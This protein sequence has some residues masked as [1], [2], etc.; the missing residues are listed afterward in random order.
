MTMDEKNHKMKTQNTV[1]DISTTKR[2]PRDIQQSNDN[3]NGIPP[4]APMKKKIKINLTNNNKSS[5]IQENHHDKEVDDI[6]SKQWLFTLNTSTEQEIHHVRWMMAT[7]ESY[8]TFTHVVGTRK[9]NILRGYFETNIPYTKEEIFTLL[10]KDY[11]NKQE[12]VVNFQKLN[13]QHVQADIPY[14]GI[15][16][17]RNGDFFSSIFSEIKDTVYF[18]EYRYGRLIRLNFAGGFEINLHGI[19][20]QGEN[21]NSNVVNYNNDDIMRDHNDIQTDEETDDENEEDVVDYLDIIKEEEEEEEEEEHQDEDD[22]DQDEET[23]S[24]D[25][26]HERNHIDDAEEIYM[27]FIRDLTGIDDVE[28]SENS[29]EDDDEDEDEDYENF[30]LK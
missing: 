29:T 20:E 7:G 27:K 18:A 21:G 5:T 1:S 10:T 8:P 3:D 4:G 13:I 26:E 28:N 12:N 23:V 11:Q 24:D 2:K 16:I 19:V 15:Y 25:N 22:D 17:E 6:F 9:N 30:N 14:M